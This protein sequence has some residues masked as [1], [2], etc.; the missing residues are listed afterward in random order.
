MAPIS[1]AQITFGHAARAAGIAEKQLRNWLDKGQVLL[2]G[3]DERVDGQW[4]RFS[5]IDV[6]RLA[7]IGTL[8][9]YGVRVSMAADII[10]DNVDSKLYSL[11]NRRN[12]PPRAMAAALHGCCIVIHVVADTTNVRLTYGP[13]DPPNTA[14]LSDYIFL[15]A[16]RISEVALM[17]LEDEQEDA[18]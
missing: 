9:R 6:I 12:A 4:R 17:R 18:D 11:A 5:F 8:V 10:R 1:R 2:Q 15:D 13:A 7:V 3:E 14:D 16:G